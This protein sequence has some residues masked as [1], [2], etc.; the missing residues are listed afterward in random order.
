MPTVAR[1][2]PAY[3]APPTGDAIT[4]KARAR[5]AWQ[6][7][8]ER[9]VL[10]API[11]DRLW[12]DTIVATRA[13]PIGVAVLMWRRSE[14]LFVLLVETTAFCPRPPFSGSW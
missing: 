10:P 7:A 14:I 9:G 5:A 4:I 1:K 3:D 2:L 11:C 13:A 12:N 8:R 6:K